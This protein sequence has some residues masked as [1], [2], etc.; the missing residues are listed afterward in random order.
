MSGQVE[1]GKTRFEARVVVRVQGKNAKVSAVS[2][3]ID[4][5][6]AEA[7]TLLLVGAGYETNLAIP[8]NVYGLGS[9]QGLQELTGGSGSGLFWWRRGPLHLLGQTNLTRADVLDR[10]LRE[11]FEEKTL[12]LFLA[13]HGGADSKGA[14]VLPEDADAGPNRLYLSTVLERLKE[15]LHAQH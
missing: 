13:L 10:V 11:R 6:E 3:A 15:L 7:A 1:D 14:Y 12:I 4:V 8:H 9:L 2:D 5:S